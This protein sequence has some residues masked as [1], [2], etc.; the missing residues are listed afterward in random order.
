MAAATWRELLA[1]NLPVSLHFFGVAALTDGGF[2]SLGQTD[3]VAFE[4]AAPGWIMGWSLTAAGTLTDC[5]FL[6][7]VAGSAVAASAFTVTAVA[8]ANDWFAPGAFP[9]AAG[10]AIAI[11][12][13]GEG[14]SDEMHIILHILYDMN[15]VV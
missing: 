2:L 1:G 12:L 15:G 9:F 13:D 14:T 4:A 8:A 3:V 7:H 10:D 6:I 5:D 11:E